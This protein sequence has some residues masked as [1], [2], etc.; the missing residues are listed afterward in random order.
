M[1]YHATFETEY[2]MAFVTVKAKNLRQATKLLKEH[3]PEDIGS[4]GFWADE[5]GNEKPIDW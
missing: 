4:D 3:H 1:E 2:G 5:D